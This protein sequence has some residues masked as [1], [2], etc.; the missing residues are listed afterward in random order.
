VDRLCDTRFLSKSARDTDDNLAF[1][2]NRLLRSEADLASLLDLYT[3]VRAGKRVPDDETNPLTGI[4]RLSGVARVENGLLHVRNRI[5]DRVFD[6]EWVLAHMPDAELR[7]QKAAY[8]RGLLRAT[9]LSGAVLAAMGVL[10]FVALRQTRIAL[11][12][13]HIAGREA[14]RADFAARR[15]AQ[16]RQV[17]EQQLYVSDMNVARQAVQRATCAMRWNLL[18]AHRPKPGEK[19]LRGWEWHYLWRLRQGESRFTF[20]GHVGTARAV[21]FSPDGTLLASGGADQTVRLLNVAT[22]R[23]LA[24]LQAYE[25]E[26][27][28]LAFSPDGRTLASG[29]DGGQ[30]SLKLWD[31]ATRREIASLGPTREGCAGPSRFHRTARR[32][33]R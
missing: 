9:L 13:T 17:A 16:Q 5:Y 8:R 26:I 20:R 29:G 14:Q 3:Q 33:P 10:T 21:A 27:R 1:V 24:T 2:R 18:E 31:V 7:R 23:Q 11:R 28:S 6:K 15:E 19:D 4:L 25:D 22:G 32:W 30:K 12:Q